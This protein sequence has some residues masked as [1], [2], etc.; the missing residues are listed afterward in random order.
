M[1]LQVSDE[2]TQSVLFLFALLFAGGG[3]EMD[4]RTG[5]SVYIY[6]GFIQS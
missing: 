4:N 3:D 5:W 6:I 1:A 2:M